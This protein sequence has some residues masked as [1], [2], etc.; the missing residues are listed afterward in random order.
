[1]RRSRFGSVVALGLAALLACTTSACAQVAKG[2]K[3]AAVQ[4]PAPTAANVEYGPYRRNVLD[5]WKADSAKPT[6]V[7]INFHGGGF[8]AGDKSAVTAAPYLK[9]GI[10]VVSANYR[11]VQGDE[12]SAPYPAPMLDGARVV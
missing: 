6:P 11:F 10:S 3:G 4:G 1:M 8:V 12:Q 7:L 9:Q 5:V 2:Q